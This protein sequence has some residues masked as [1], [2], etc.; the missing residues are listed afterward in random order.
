MIL[1]LIPGSQS[2]SR[3]AMVHRSKRKNGPLQL[4]SLAYSAFSFGCREQTDMSNSVHDYTQRAEQSMRCSP[5][6]CGLGEQA[7]RKWPQSCLLLTDTG[8]KAKG[9]DAKDE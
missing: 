7:V 6:A 8:A 2:C 5:L 1:D 3:Q 4:P 9:E